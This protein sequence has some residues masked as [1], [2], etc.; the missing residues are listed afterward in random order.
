MSTHSSPCRT[1]QHLTESFISTNRTGIPMPNLSLLDYDSGAE[2]DVSFRSFRLIQPNS[3]TRPTSGTSTSFSVPTLSFACSRSSTFPIYNNQS[4]DD[5]G[6]SHYYNHFDDSDQVH[7]HGNSSTLF[8]KPIDPTVGPQNSD[9]SVHTATVNYQRL[10]ANLS[11]KLHAEIMNAK[12]DDGAR[13]EAADAGKG[14]MVDGRASRGEE[15]GGYTE[16]ATLSLSTRDR[17]LASLESLRR[18]NSLTAGGYE[19]YK[20]I[21]TSSLCDLADAV[22]AV[23]GF[24]E[25]TSLLSLTKGLEGCM[26]PEKKGRN[27]T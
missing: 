12:W 8:L 18:A 19:N 25:K 27:T 20:E 23:D 11:A 4:G 3:S 24:T 13:G 9:G 1:P 22:Y 2:P 15:L 21:V 16:T 7:E 17:A 6:N 14:M 5:P 10:A 26:L